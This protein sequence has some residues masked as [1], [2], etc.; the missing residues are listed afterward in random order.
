MKSKITITFHVFNKSN[1]LIDVIKKTGFV[2]PT[3]IRFVEKLV[4]SKHGTNQTIKL[5]KTNKHPKYD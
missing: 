2:K 5:V 3:I 1:K 4:L